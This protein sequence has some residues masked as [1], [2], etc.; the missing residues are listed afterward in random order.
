MMP[1]SSSSASFFLRVALRSLRSAS[2]CSPA[3]DGGGIGLGGGMTVPDIGVLVSGTWSAGGVSDMK[4]SVGSVF[5][6]PSA[7]RSSTQAD[8]S[9][10]VTRPPSGTTAPS[11]TR[12]GTP[13][14][15]AI[16]AMVAA[17]CSSLPT[18]CG[19]LTNSSDSRHALWPAT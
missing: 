9:L 18:I 15:L 10:P 14:S 3:S 13:M 4:A 7:A 5:H 17:Y 19:A 16:S 11:T 1:S 2:L 8:T 12:A 6:D